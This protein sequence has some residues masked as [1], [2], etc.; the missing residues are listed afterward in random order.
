M[1]GLIKLEIINFFNAHQVIKNTADSELGN[2]SDLFLESLINLDIWQLN[3][4]K[5]FR[6]N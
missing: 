3:H 4:Q 5:Q 1:K 2:S 6:D